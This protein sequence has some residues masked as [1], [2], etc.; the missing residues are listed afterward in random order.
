MRGALSKLFFQSRETGDSSLISVQTRPTRRVPCPLFSCP[1]TQYN[2]TKLCDSARQPVCTN[3]FNYIGNPGALKVATMSNYS[4]IRAASNADRRSGARVTPAQP[5]EDSK[6]AHRTGFGINASDRRTGQR[7]PFRLSESGGYDGARERD[8]RMNQA[9]NKHRNDATR[10][11]RQSPSHNAN[12]ILTV[13]VLCSIMEPSSIF[14][15]RNHCAPCVSHFGPPSVIVSAERASATAASR[16]VSGGAR[17]C[18]LRRR[19]VC[20]YGI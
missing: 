4:T 7:S 11:A 12:L 3:T 9:V 18:N 19:T 16:T 17:I 14:G 13:R 6:I 15:V 5:Q 8:L 2:N 20:I 10:C 1:T